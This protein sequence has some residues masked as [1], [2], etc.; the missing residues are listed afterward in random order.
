MKP[1]LERLTADESRFSG[2]TC[3]EVEEH[4]WHHCHRRT[5]GRKPT[6]TVDLARYEDGREY[7]RL[8]DLVPGR[9]RKAY[10]YTD[11][12]DESGGRCA[13]ARVGPTP[14]P[15]PRQRRQAAAI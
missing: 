8:L 2:V 3:L 6:K 14:R 1:E 7:A 15:Q 10:T 5:R 13:R 12:L 4:V 11:W 9:L